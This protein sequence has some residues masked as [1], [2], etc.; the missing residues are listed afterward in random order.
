MR[1]SK[2]PASDHKHYCNLVRNLSGEYLLFLGHESTKIYATKTAR[3]FGQ[4]SIK[5]SDET[6]RTVH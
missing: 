2:L 6:H 4:V 3:Q 5:S 1:G